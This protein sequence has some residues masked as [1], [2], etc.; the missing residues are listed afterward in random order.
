MKDFDLEP[1]HSQYM[2]QFF[3]GDC[4]VIQYTY[5]VAGKDN[6]V[7][8]Y[9]QGLKS[10]TDEKGTSA[11]KAVEL[12]DK[13]GGA[14]VQVHNYQTDRYIVFQL[15]VLKHWSRSYMYLYI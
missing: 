11:L 1:I 9:W 10:T 3:A 14:A 8:Y 15:F 4:Y 13:L 5:K 12:D 6:H 7:I 2:G